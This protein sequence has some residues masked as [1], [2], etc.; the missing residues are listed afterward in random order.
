MNTKVD[1]N[2][3]Q[4]GGDHYRTAY[5]HWDF[6]ADIGLPYHPS[7]ASKYVTRY[8]K[9]NG[10]QDL[11]KAIHFLEKAIDKVDSTQNCLRWLAGANSSIS[12]QL[13]A[14]ES[15]RRAYLT[16]FKDV[17]FGLPELRPHNSAPY[18]AAQA[19]HYMCIPYIDAPAG[20]S[21]NEFLD[22]IVDDHQK[23][24]RYVLRLLDL[25]YPPPGSD[26]TPAYVNQG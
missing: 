6:V 2:A 11:R 7:C 21:Y 18:L 25:Q 9:K 17:S 8:P 26:A 20:Q 22:F 5:Q 15:L 19:V 4:V 3:T 10:E 24:K 12:K 14:S 13:L 16:Q 23:A 1:V